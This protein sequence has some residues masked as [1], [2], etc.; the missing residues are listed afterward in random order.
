MFPAKFYQ[1][2][3]NCKKLIALDTGHIDRIFVLFKRVGRRF[4][5]KI[6]EPAKIAIDF[7]GILI[8]EKVNIFIY[9]FIV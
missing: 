2:L 8:T 5:Y 4:K 3:T 7:M 6:E 1:V 9:A